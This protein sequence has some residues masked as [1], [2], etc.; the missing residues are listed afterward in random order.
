MPPGE[1]L[2]GTDI[3]GRDMY[4]RVVYGA[5]VSLQIGIASTLISVIIGVTLG[6]LAGYYG[7]LADDIISWLIN[8]VFAFPFLL[9]VLAMVA[10]LPPGL[11]LMY[12]A[13]GMVNWAGVAS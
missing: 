9:F 5:R 4:S 3:Y 8:V 6:A 1:T 13:I 11:P 7:G 10:Y 12:A 2:F